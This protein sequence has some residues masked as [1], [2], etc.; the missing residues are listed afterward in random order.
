MN[1]AD[2]LPMDLICKCNFPSAIFGLTRREAA[3]KENKF[4]NCSAQFA[5]ALPKGRVVGG[6]LRWR[7]P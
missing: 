4:G 6:C 2:L 1:K 5:L 7:F 3:L